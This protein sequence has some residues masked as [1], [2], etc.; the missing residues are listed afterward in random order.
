MKVLVCHPGA[1]WATHDVYTACVEG[2]RH[3][4]AAVVEWRLDGRIERWHAF[5]HYLWRKQRREKQGQHWP[6]PT[7][8]DTLHMATTGLVERAIEKGCTDLVIVSAMFLP[9]E[10]ITLAKRAGLRVWLLCTETPYDIADELRLAQMVDGVWTHERAALPLFAAVNPRTAYLPHA[11]RPGVHDVATPA[12]VRPCDV[13][14]CG[15]YFPERIAWF[16]SI[17]WAGIDLHL[18]G[19]TELIPASSPLRQYVRG[20]LVPNAEL[21][22]LAKT[23]AILINFFRDPA[24]GHVAESVNPRIVELAAAGVCVIT[25][26]RAEVTEMF[27]EAV[28]TFTTAAEAGALIRAL[29]ADPFRRR[30]C[31]DTARARVAEAHWHARGQQMI[32]DLARWTRGGEGHHA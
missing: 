24:A 32:D 13:L 20:G 15:S 31:A 10:K 21:V 1:S 18:Y 7:P 14:F 5:L 9:P 29:L 22:R 3:A 19:V 26:P 27:G 16:E 4:G 2:L 8:A 11:W 17:D 30:A 28:P 23:A 12:P 25:D 6:K